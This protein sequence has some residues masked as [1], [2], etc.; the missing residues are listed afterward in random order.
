MKRKPLCLVILGLLPQGISAQTFSYTEEKD[1]YSL[2]VVESNPQHTVLQFTL[3]RFETKPITIEGTPYQIL[4]MSDS[5]IFNKKGLPQ[6]PK[7]YRHVEIPSSGTPIIRVTGEAHDELALGMVAPSKGDILRN[8]DPES[9]PYFF[10][11]FYQGKSGGFPKAPATLSAPFHFRNARGVTVKLHPFIFNPKTNKTTVYRRLTVEVL[12]PNVQ[13][14]MLDNKT[15]KDSD[16]FHFLYENQFINH[17]E[18]VHTMEI[19]SNNNNV[20]ELGDL[21]IVSHPNFVSGLAP[22]IAWKQQLGFRVQLATLTQTGSSASSIKS[23][24][25]KTYK[26]NPK[27]AYV[28]LVGDAKYMPY[29]PGTA[30]NAYGNEA[31]PLYGVTSANNTYPDLIIGRFSVQNTTELATMINRTIAYEK[32]PTSGD[33]YEHAVGIASAEG[34]PT[35]G[36]REDYVRN[37][38]LR[39]S[40]QTVEQLYDPYV[41]DI[42]IAAAVNGG[43]SLIN[44]IGH[45]SETAWVTG[46]FS[47]VDVRSLRNTGMYPMIVSVACVNGHFA[48]TGGD[49]LAEAWLKA[50]TP[51][52][53]T[54]A[55]AMFAS[56]TNQAWVP[57]T[58]GQL[59]IAKLVASHTVTHVGALMLDGSIAVLEDGSDDADQTFQTWHIFGDPTAVLRTQSPQ[60]IM[61]EPTFETRGSENIQL[62]VAE[63]GLRV[64][65]TN[66]KQLLGTTVSNEE[67]IA[68]FPTLSLAHG[69]AF[70]VTV[71][72]DNLVP[73]VSQLTAP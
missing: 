59:A 72:G 73:Q 30:G 9:V 46:W 68:S 40:Y 6:V 15:E 7:V 66:G 19:M 29:Y 4:S 52:R 56:S 61:G 47:N 39:G 64:S 45:G 70:T 53:P 50:G 24:I 8:V 21:L 49:V 67:G 16:A 2:E 28:L 65:L 25:Q 32:T 31:D 10:D 22:F 26:A 42:D 27:L 62:Q 13:G 41:Q 37:T 48:Y 23:Y 20:R 71:S 1:G 54:G 33:W 14:T 69:E 11:S 36:A 18:L 12:T 44:Y 58:I 3:N 51:S 57:P 34:N 38:L 55:L 43:T 17:G 60:R 35:D 63:S 5:G